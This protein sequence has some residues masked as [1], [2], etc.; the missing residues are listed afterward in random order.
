MMWRCSKIWLRSNAIWHLQAGW[1]QRICPRFSRVALVQIG[2]EHLCE[3]RPR[4]MDPFDHRIVRPYVLS[5]IEGVHTEHL[6]VSSSC[7]IPFIALLFVVNKYTPRN[8][9]RVSRTQSQSI[10]LCWPVSFLSR[11]CC[12]VSPSSDCVRLESI[13]NLGKAA[14]MGKS[15]PL[16]FLWR[17]VLLVQPL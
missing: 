15:I 11:K 13:H 2:P 4:G 9:D 8:T 1:L 3:I 14:S 5:N 7:S 6:L 10:L 17:Y 12:S 16:C